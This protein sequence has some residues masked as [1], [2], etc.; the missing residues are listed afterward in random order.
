[1]LNDIVMVDIEGI[2]KTGHD[3]RYHFLDNLVVGANRLLVAFEWGSLM[4]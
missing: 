1:M 4:L 3:N 2:S